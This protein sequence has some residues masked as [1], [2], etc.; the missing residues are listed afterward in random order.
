MPF[1]Y[2]ILNDNQMGKNDY[3]LKKAERISSRIEIDSLF[4][5]G[6]SFLVFPLRIV[7]LII[8]EGGASLPKT[9][10]LVSVSK[11]RFKHAVNRNRIKRLVRETFRLNKSSILTNSLLP[12]QQLKI[13]FLYI[14]SEEMGYQD[15]DKAM[16]KAVEILNK[17]IS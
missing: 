6:E 7:Y 3:T 12:E 14:H 13:A 16:R 5:K 11:K 15:I 1:F 17:K 10:M 2:I 9:S 4:A 8:P